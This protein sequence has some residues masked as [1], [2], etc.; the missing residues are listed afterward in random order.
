M[1]DPQKESRPIIKE[2]LEANPLFKKKAEEVAKR[3]NITL[4]EAAT[5][6]I[7]WW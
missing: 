5:L 6:L 2:I 7:E 4:E 3:H 1:S